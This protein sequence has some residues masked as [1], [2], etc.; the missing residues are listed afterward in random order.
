MPST[1]SDRLGL[2]APLTTENADGPSLAQLLIDQLDLKVA[3]VKIADGALAAGKFTFSA[4][5]QEFT[6][7]RVQGLV[8]TDNATLP[9]LGLRFNGVTL[10]GGSGG[11]EWTRVETNP[12]SSTAT[13]HS[14]LALQSQIALGPLLVSPLQLLNFDA[15][16]LWAKDTNGVKYVEFSSALRAA[17]S[18]GS[19]ELHSYRGHGVM[20]DTPAVTSIELVSVTGNLVSP[21]KAILSGIL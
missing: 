1:P 16:V 7:L 3:E 19:L 2:Q 20:K 11:Y 5:P 10:I 15:T 13:S 17:L 9:E 4:I 12:A 18:G 21:S 14:G 6:H 8:R